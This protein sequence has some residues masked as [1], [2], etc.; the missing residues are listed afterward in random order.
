MPLLDQF[1]KANHEIFEPRIFGMSATGG[2]LKK[3][4]VTA[5]L[6]KQRDPV[7]WIEV[8]GPEVKPHDITAP[9]RYVME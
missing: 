8:V 3:Q 4:E 6:H 1:L 9:V 2:D 5:E 7:Q